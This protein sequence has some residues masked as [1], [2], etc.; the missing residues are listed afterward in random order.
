M[1]SYLTEFDKN[2]VHESHRDFLNPPLMPTAC[3]HPGNADIQPHDNCPI[4]REWKYLMQRQYSKTFEH[5]I[6]HH[7]RYLVSA[8]ND[9]S[10]FAVYAELA[11][12]RPQL[13]QHH[14]LTPVITPET[15]IL[16]DP[17]VYKF[18]HGNVRKPRPHR[19]KWDKK[20]KTYTI[21]HVDGYFPSLA[22]ANNAYRVV[23][24]EN[25]IALINTQS[26]RR[27]I[28]YLEI[29]LR[30]MNSKFKRY[31]KKFKNKVRT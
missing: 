1:I 25:L 30:A 15:W 2:M 6:F 11:K 21:R 17:L 16:V 4:F 23:E 10:R 22:E 19:L 18:L 24:M 5:T 20:Y 31:S 3:F 27:V 29:K 13:T 28:D 9:F 8:W 7:H 14:H 12:M 26:D